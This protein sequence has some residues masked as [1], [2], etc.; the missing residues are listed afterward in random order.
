M[1]G[2][3]VDP[4]LR[5]T[6]IDMSQIKID[7]IQRRFNVKPTNPILIFADQPLEGVAARW[8]LIP[9]WFKGNDPKE[10]KATTFN[11]RI[12]EAREKPTFRAAWR[13]GR[14]L[15]PAG[16]FYE[17]TGPK[18]NRRPNFFAP[19]GNDA[20]FYFAGLFSIWNDMRTC[21][22]M[23]RA[24]TDAMVGIHN[25]MPVILNS[26]EREAWLEGSADLNIGIRAALKTWPVERFGL[27][28]EGVSLIEAAE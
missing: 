6:E 28:D 11:A 13:Y 8:G 1:C 2:R 27:M 10:W 19:A 24:A 3:F 15:I 5:N 26:E 7:P 4:N 21:T 12:E 18:G 22:I 25:R 9:S 20:N 16:G 17:W 23:T 14:C